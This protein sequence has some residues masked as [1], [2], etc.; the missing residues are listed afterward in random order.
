LT[1][2]FENGILSLCNFEDNLKN[3]H[4]IIVVRI[5]S[6]L[7]AA[8]FDRRVIPLI[9]RLDDILIRRLSG[10][11]KIF[12]GIWFKFHILIDD[13]LSSLLELTR[14]GFRAEASAVGSP[15]GFEFYH[16][17]PGFG[18]LLIFRCCGPDTLKIV[19]EFCF[20]L[21]MDKEKF[22]ILNLSLDIT[23]SFP[24]FRCFCFHG[25][26]FLFSFFDTDN[27]LLSLSFMFLLI[28][29]LFFFVICWMC[30]V[31]TFCMF[32]EFNMLFTFSTVYSVRF[33]HGNID[34]CFALLFDIS[35]WIFLDLLPLLVSTFGVLLV[36]FSSCHF[37]FFVFSF[38]IGLL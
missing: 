1:L 2:D 25:R 29:Q 18:I 21:I 14:A 10:F 26:I 28:Y 24:S 3:D 6:R 12:A 32:T 20:F 7:D 34:L 30:F 4:K 35:C 37:T 36:F 22:F 23:V 17:L 11:R 8:I 27:F 9:N 5:A 13:M 31:A 19:L 33:L 38:F 16:L 15:F